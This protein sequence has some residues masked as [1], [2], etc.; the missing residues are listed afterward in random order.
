MRQFF[1][2]L[3]QGTVEGVT[4]VITLTEMTVRPLQLALPYVAD[5]YEVYLT[6]YPHLLLRD[7]D[8]AIARRAAELRAGYRLRLGDSLQV[9][10]GLEAGAA[11]FLTNDRDLRRVREIPVLILDDFREE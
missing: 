7:I 10:T 3:A 4:S 1:L 9:A 6:A 11:A 8:R 5:S 2:D